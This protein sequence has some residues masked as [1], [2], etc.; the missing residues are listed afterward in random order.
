MMQVDVASAD[1][2]F[3]FVV[4][5]P[6]RYAVTVEELGFQ[7]R[8]VVDVP[9]RRAREVDFTFELPY[10]DPPVMTIDTVPFPAS[11]LELDPLSRAFGRLELEQVPDGRRNLG[12]LGEQLALGGDALE[13]NGLPAAASGVVS[14]GLRIR[15]AGHPWL[16]DRTQLSEFVPSALVRSTLVSDE[17]DVEWSGYAGGW[18]LGD[19]RRARQRLEVSLFGDWTGDALVSSDRIGGDLASFGSARGGLRV[20]GP[21]LPDTAFFVLGA[22]VNQ[23]RSPLPRAWAPRPVDDALEAS[24]KSLGVDP[25]PLLR[26]RVTE[27]DAAAVYGRSDWRLADGQQLSVRGQ[28]ASVTGDGV[29]VGPD[30]TWTPETTL[31]GSDLAAT[32]SLTSY[33]GAAVANEVR[34][35]FPPLHRPPSHVAA[36]STAAVGVRVRADRRTPPSCSHARHVMT[37]SVREFSGSQSEWDDF[38]TAQPQSKRFHQFG[39][40]QIIESV[41]GHECIYLESRSESE[42]LNGVLPLL[43]VRSHLFGPFLVSMPFLNYGGPVG[44]PDAVTALCEAATKRA[45]EHGADLLE[46]RGRHELVTDLAVSHRKITVASR[47]SQGRPR[48]AL[49]RSQDESAQPGTTSM[50][51]GVEVRFVRRELG[52]FYDIF[53]R[54]MRDLGTPAQSRGLFERIGDEFPESVWFGCAYLRGCP[55]ASGCG[56]RWDDEFEIIWASSLRAY[57]RIA[58]NMLLYWKFMERC[59]EEGIRVFNFGRCTPGSGMH[60]FKRQRGSRD[61]PLWWY[62]AGPGRKLDAP[63]PDDGRYSWGLRVWRRLPMAVASAVGPR[64]VQYIP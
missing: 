41:F 45:E 27:T 23:V 6:G 30:G 9:V 47:P 57:N 62:Q 35:G 16:V 11:A 1:G 5:A 59:V 28:F 52:P 3:R 36:S 14:D 60:R 43:R 18:I 15:G 44:E 2:G 10:A 55:V 33:W 42:T 49:G 48:S 17:T 29:D 25:A 13:I 51:E 34:V 39:W 40:K 37:P 32:A 20:G 4:L 21:I 64:V 38:V 26:P 22:Q 50:K 7:P 61:Q 58:P 54:H 46:L 56:F 24:T 31:D 8:T 63:S 19:T 12:E 53:C